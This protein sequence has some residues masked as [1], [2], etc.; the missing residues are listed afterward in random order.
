MVDR[1]PLHEILSIE[2]MNEDP[3]LSKTIQ[4]SS[5]KAQSIKSQC[6]RSQTMKSSSAL[7]F[8]RTNSSTDGVRL[9]KDKIGIESEPRKLALKGHRQCIIQ[10]KT[11]PEGFN[12]G[13]TYYLKANYDTPDRLIITQLSDARINAKRIAE[14][15]SRIQQSRDLM[16]TVQESL[17]FQFTVA[18]L[19]LLVRAL[20]RQ[21]P[22][23]NE[24]FH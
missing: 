8:E 20:S 10:L 1:I 21:H 23:S 9:R 13:R 3:D 15:K 17:V 4:S 11:L 6:I 7:S 24:V 14:R 5:I 19:I 12:L 22:S 2:E 18:V 16:R